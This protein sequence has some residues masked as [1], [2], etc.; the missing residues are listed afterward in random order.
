MQVLLS[1]LP[2]ALMLSFSIVLPFVVPEEPLWLFVVRALWMTSAFAANFVYL[3]EQAF[4]KTADL[5]ILGGLFLLVAWTGQM[6]L[7]LFAVIPLSDIFIASRYRKE[8]GEAETSG[9]FRRSFYF[10]SI[11]LAVAFV[12]PLAV[13]VAVG[14]TVGKCITLLLGVLCWYLAFVCLSGKTKT[15]SVYE[16]RIPFTVCAIPLAMSTWMIGEDVS[17]RDITLCISVA[18]LMGLMLT[19]CEK[20][21]NSKSLS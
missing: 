3:H 15:V 6:L 7:L 14:M 11:V 20:S 13:T 18:L 12:A 9:N 2:L 10:L 17:T 8:K 4:S 19:A 5:L 21:W 1:N 16:K